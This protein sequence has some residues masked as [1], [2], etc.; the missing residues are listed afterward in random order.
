MRASVRAYACALLN[1]PKLLLL[2][3]PTAGLD[4]RSGAVAEISLRGSG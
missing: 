1:D 2:D 3:E 4:P